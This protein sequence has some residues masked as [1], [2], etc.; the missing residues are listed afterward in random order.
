MSA[1]YPDDDWDA[2]LRQFFPEDFR[3]DE[4]ADS[5]GHPPTYKGVMPDGGRGGVP[6][7]LPTYPKPDRRESD[8][9]LAQLKEQIN[10]F[11][12]PFQE[13]NRGGD[14]KASQLEALFQHTRMRE[15]ADWAE[16]VAQYNMAN[17]KWQRLNE[18]QLFTS[19]GEIRGNP[20][21]T[22]SV[23]GRMT[24][25]EYGLEEQRRR[26]A[27]AAE[28]NTAGIAGR[29]K[30]AGINR[31][32][33]IGAANIS[34]AARRDTA[35]PPAS[36]APGK[37]TDAQKAELTQ[38]KAE[39][40]AAD[41]ILGSAKVLSG[42]IGPDD[43][44]VLQATRRKALAVKRARQIV[45]GAQPGAAPQSG[46]TKSGAKWT[47][48]SAAPATGGG[49]RFVDEDNITGDEDDEEE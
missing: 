15:D 22:P 1:N 20:W 46:T 31:A 42:E 43:P 45:A 4:E 35:R 41:K 49:S 3:N 37:L 36:A 11:P 39:V 28:R 8:A 34:A 23:I 29:E 17:P 40:A 9:V 30:V 33:R 16:K 6:A 26:D 10:R 24:T 13:M 32:A 12:W 7:T 25:G 38:L 44:A 27:A 18:G 48:V 21:A 14:I 5:T 2:V 19:T 47:L